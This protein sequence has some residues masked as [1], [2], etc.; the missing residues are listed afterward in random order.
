MPKTLF[1]LSICL[2]IGVLAL[3]GCQSSNTNQTI[4]VEGSR[5]TVE[6]AQETCRDLLNGVVEPFKDLQVFTDENYTEVTITSREA[7]D[8]ERLPKQVGDWEDKGY[9]CFPLPLEFA[10]TDTNDQGVQAVTKVEWSCE[11]YWDDYEYL[12]SGSARVAE[13]EKAGYNCS[14]QSCLND[15]GTGEVILCTK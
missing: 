3:A 14:A 13:L 2:V 12:E 7:W 10:A 15:D 1:I 4:E 5:E 9:T 8:R 6:T 11:L